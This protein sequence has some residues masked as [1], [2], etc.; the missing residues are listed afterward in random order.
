M[1]DVF[2]SYKR[3]ERAQIERLAAALRDLGLSVWFDASL[4]AG[5]SFSSEI[6]R[7]AR[8]AKAIL[9]CWSPTARESR[10]VIAEAQIG[11]EKDNLAAAYVAGPDGFAPPV[12]FNTIHAEDLRAWLSAPDLV[13]SGWR[14]LL[15]RIGKLC[16]RADMESFGALDA[17]ASAAQLNAWLTKHESSPLFMAVDS[18]LQARRTAEAERTALEHAAREKRRREEEEARQHAERERLER[19]QAASTAEADALKAAA[20]RR[21]RFAS[22]AAAAGVGG[23]LLVGAIFAL[24]LMNGQTRCSNGAC[25]NAETYRETA[26]ARRDEFDLAVVEPLVNRPQPATPTNTAPSSRIGDETDHRNELAVSGP[27]SLN[28]GTANPATDASRPTDNQTTRGTI[29]WTQRPSARVM[30]NLYPASALQQG[31]G[32]GPL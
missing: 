3:E 28:P 23:V 31:I 9:V 22:V 1:A 26:S 19:E 7:E 27:V 10:W 20:R 5:E 32:E 2:I 29:T 18:L 14:S 30:A 4:S 25:G 21:R 17:Q 13:H 15:R 6:D 12:P 11:F 8:A 16:Q 24:D